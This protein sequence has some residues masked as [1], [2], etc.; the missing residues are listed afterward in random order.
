MT[1]NI[2]A[3]DV[4]NNGELAKALNISA[5]TLSRNKDRILKQL[6]ECYDYEIDYTKTGNIS[7]IHFLGKICDYEYASANSINKA[8]KTKELEWA[9]PQILREQPLNTAK[10]ISRIL[11]NE[12]PEVRKYCS[13]EGS[14]YIDTLVNMKIWFGKSEYDLPDLETEMKVRKGRIVGRAWTMLDKDNNVYI[15]MSEK[16]VKELRGLFDKYLHN[17][18]AIKEEQERIFQDYEMH[19]ITKEEMQSMIGDTRFTGYNAA[20]QAYKE[21]YGYMPVPANIYEL[22]DVEDEN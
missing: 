19:N 14:L 9:I 10:N 22:Y 3:G 4:F 5:R 17:N 16:Q 20:K 7:K 13:S 8:M 12:Y 18:E 11:W 15:L 21:K 1:A 6:A 2:N